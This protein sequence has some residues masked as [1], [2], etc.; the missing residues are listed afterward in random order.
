MAVPLV[1]DG[2]NLLYALGEGPGR[3]ARERLTHDLIRYARQ[4]GR[5]VVL[6]FDAWA[7]GGPAEQASARGPVSVLYT[8]RGERADERIRRW[9]AARREAVVVTSDR[10]VARAVERLGAVALS[11]G[12]FAER[13][14]AA[15]SPAGDAEGEDEAPSPR[16]RLSGGARRAWLRGL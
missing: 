15:L 10:E 5:Q 16:A 13:L 12:A 7:Q 11:A 8:R 3:E 2:Y 9:V 14:A 4:R 6:V 1:I